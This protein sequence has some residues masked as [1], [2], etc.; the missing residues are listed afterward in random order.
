MD[1]LIQIYRRLLEEV[2]PAYYRK[3]YSD[4]QMNNRF[5]GVVGARGVGKTTFLLQYLKE[6]F[7]DS[8]KGLYISGDNLYFTDHTLLETADQFVKLYAG[9]L[10]CIDEVHKYKNWNQELK[11][12]F[13][14][15][16]NLKVLFSGSSSIDLIKGKY[17][18]SR[19][20]I[21]RQMYGFSFR[22]YLEFKTGNKYP[23]ITLKEIFEA[24]S[25][26]DKKI[27]ATEKLLGYLHE[28]WKRGYYPTSNIITSYEAF[29]DTLIGVIDKTIYED[30]TSFYALK[31]EN[32]DALKKIVYFFATSEPGSISI[33]KL[34]HSL[35]KDHATVTEYVQILR[36]TGILRFLL[37]DKSGHALIRNAE[38]VYLD[39][40]NLLYAVN[41]TIGKE[42]HI[43]T[44]RELFAVSS[45]EDSGYKVFY[46]KK[47]D[48]LTDG[49]TLEI[50]GP[51][52][53]G[54]QVQDDILY[55]SLNIRPLYLFGFLR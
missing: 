29:K 25:H 55:G 52:K 33:N 40:T 44:V 32:L 24:T 26:I 31:T 17:D 6:H 18:L 39:N 54:I 13:D 27:G 23:V 53:S 51:N 3:F 7:G 43:G 14:S 48:I 34:A 15:Y 46:S 35:G 2:K 36:D 28:Y 12:I 11:N 50:G 10:L 38:K 41:E 20:V 45:L 37:I 16:P 19:R 1:N 8:E 49:H 4:F 42:V 47:G 30:I 21:L 22:E 5:I 9:E